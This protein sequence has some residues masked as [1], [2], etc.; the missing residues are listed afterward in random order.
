M[1]SAQAKHCR[2]K[3]IECEEEA[4]RAMSPMTAE[5]RLKLENWLDANVAQYKDWSGDFTTPHVK[6]VMSTLLTR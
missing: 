4:D 6:Q 3:A 2:Q 1:R 5:A